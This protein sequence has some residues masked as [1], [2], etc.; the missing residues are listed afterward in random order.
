[1]QPYIL[2]GWYAHFWK[3]NKIIVVYNDK[4]FELVKNNRS[5]WKGTGDT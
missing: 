4:Q 3:E 2:R 5:T 1:M